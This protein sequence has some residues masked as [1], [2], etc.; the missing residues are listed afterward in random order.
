MSKRNDTYRLILGDVNDLDVI[1]V[2]G[3]L[4]A[5]GQVLEVPDGDVG[6][7][8]HVYS[9]LRGN[10]SPDLALRRELGREGL[11]VDFAVRAPCVH[12]LVCVHD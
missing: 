12:V 10:E 7:R 11:G 8:R 9:G 4:D 6:V 5:R 2:D 3:L 1:T